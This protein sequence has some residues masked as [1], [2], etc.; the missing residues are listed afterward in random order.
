V[1]LG[2]VAR[3]RGAV[4]KYAYADCEALSGHAPSFMKAS[5]GGHDGM[6]AESGDGGEGGADGSKAH[7]DD[8]SHENTLVGQ[9]E[10]T[11]PKRGSAMVT[12]DT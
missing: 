8:Y 10:K 12:S 1:L 2:R 6:R 5:G 3:A 7:V 11:N 9:S 4:L